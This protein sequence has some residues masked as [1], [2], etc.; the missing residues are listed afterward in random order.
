LCQGKSIRWQISAPDVPI[1]LAGC[2]FIGVAAVL[3]GFVAPAIPNVTDTARRG[4]DC[5]WLPIPHLIT[6]AAASGALI[7]IKPFAS[8]KLTHAGVGHNAG[9]ACLIITK[10][11]V[12]SGIDRRC[13]A[14][15]AFA[16]PFLSAA[17]PGWGH[18]ER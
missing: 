12:A 3:F 16:G 15:A 13:L 7:K 2:T 1:A 18:Q 14:V 10:P 8:R 9:K 4:F 6:D 11:T 5:N 17:I